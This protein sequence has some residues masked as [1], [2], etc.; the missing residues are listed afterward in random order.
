MP[1]PKN[2]LLVPT[3]ARNAPD[4][5][6][7]TTYAPAPALFPR[8]DDAS[9]TSEFSDDAALRVTNPTD[10][11]SDRALSANPFALEKPAPPAKRKRGRP[12]GDTYSPAEETD[13]KRGRK[14]LDQTQRQVFRFF[15]RWRRLEYKSGVTKNQPP[16]QPASSAHATPFSYQPG[17][18]PAAPAAPEPASEPPLTFQSLRDEFASH[19]A[20]KRYYYTHLYELLALYER[21]QIPLL[22]PVSNTRD[23]R[24][25]RRSILHSFY[26]LGVPAQTRLVDDWLVERTARQRKRHAD[27]L[28][29]CLAR[30]ALAK[31]K[32]D[33][34]ALVR[35][36]DFV[37]NEDGPPEPWTN[38]FDRI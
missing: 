1:R 20:S 17:A 2:C 19:N 35:S 38:L 5:R 12:W 36:I 3:D 11:A 28:E 30:R 26:F 25:R 23:V 18:E 24:A 27:V 22:A 13:R 34:L 15:C 6:T 14:T 29:T 33:I 32:T 16:Q 31:I 4:P 21:Q 9:D 8:T 7:Q 37:L 10:E